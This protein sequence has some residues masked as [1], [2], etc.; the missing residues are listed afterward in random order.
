MATVLQR[1]REARI[2]LVAEKPIQGREIAGALIARDRLELP[3]GG[4]RGS[5]VDGTE[6][7]VAWAEGHLMEMVKPDDMKPEWGSPWRKEVLPMIPEGG[8]I[9]RRPI[10]GKKGRLDVLAGWMHQASEVVNACDAGPEGELIFDEIVH[11]ANLE[12]ESETGPV[13]FTRMWIDDTRVDALRA[14]FDDRRRSNLVRAMNQREAAYARA[15]ADWLYG[16]N[17]T[18]FAT[19]AMRSPDLPLLVVGRVQTPTLGAVATR[20]LDILTFEP[21]QFE[22]VPMTFRGETGHTFKAFLVAFPNIR[23]GNVDHHFHPVPELRDI[24][25][26]LLMTAAS[27]WR[28]MDMAEPRSEHPP[29]PF[30]LIDLQRSAFNIFR[31]PAA[32]TLKI[33]QALYAREKAIT[34]PRTDSQKIPTGMRDQVEAMRE[35][36]YYGWALDRF[37]GLKGAKLVTEDAH[38]TGSASEHHAILPTGIVP[39]AW[40]QYDQMRD[41]YRLWE[42]IVVRTILSWLPPASIA[43]VKR[44]MMRPW[45]KDTVIRASIEAEPVDDPGWLWWEDKMMNTRGY[46]PPLAERLRETALPD[47][48][49]IAIMAG[50]TITT[51]YTSPP[52]HFDESTLLGWMQRASL[53]TAA[54]RAQ[55]IEDLIH[56]GYIVRSDTGQ[57]RAS[58]EGSLM[59]AMFKAK[60]EDELTGDRYARQTEE[61]VERIGSMAKERPSRKRLWESVESKVRAVGAKLLDQPIDRDVGYCPKTG[62]QATLH[63]SGKFY[64][65]A[66]FKDAR[67]FVS[68]LGRKMTAGDYADILAGEARGAGPFPGFTSKAG[69]KFQ[70]FLCYFPKK[71]KVEFMFNR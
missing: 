13:S 62:H 66:G 65:F 12:Q 44:L 48:G 42:L 38:W 36:L 15:D 20:D 40:D 50:L 41:E 30:D 25:Q 58:R 54:T 52:K 34:Y 68:I 51:G 7:I 45:T 37:P 61:F 9:P 59:V 49:Q 1:K 16:F 57:I 26:E 47:A 23:H 19:C 24:R 17:C 3:Q 31:W 22:R 28:V 2:L 53:G 33:A 63:K 21:S 10:P 55:V 71:K 6:I 5:L 56:Y 69:N 67:F 27:P 60:L 18:R 70:A 43:A 8:F 35:K 29:S 14:A 11:Y 46:G 32:K 4:V 64:E 39:Q